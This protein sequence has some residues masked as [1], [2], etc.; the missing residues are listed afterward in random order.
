MTSCVASLSVS[1]DYCPKR[2]TLIRSL[3]YKIR[4]NY[5]NKKNQ[6]ITF[7]PLIK[8]SLSEFSLPGTIIETALFT[9]FSD[10]GGALARRRRD[11]FSFSRLLYNSQRVFL[12]LVLLLPWNSSFPT[13]CSHKA[14]LHDETIKSLPVNLLYL[15]WNFFWPAFSMK[16]DCLLSTCSLTVISENSLSKIYRSKDLKTFVVLVASYLY[17][18][19]LK[20][21]MS[22]PLDWSSVLTPEPVMILTTE[23]LS[24]TLPSSRPTAPC[25]YSRSGT[26][27]TSPTKATLGFHLLGFSLCCGPLP[28][29]QAIAKNPSPPAIHYRARFDYFI[30]SPSPSISL[31]CFHGLINRRLCSCPEATNNTRCCEH[32]FQ[33]LLLNCPL[34]KVYETLSGESIDEHSFLKALSLTH[35]VPLSEIQRNDIV[36]SNSTS[37]V[38]IISA[39]SSRGFLGSSILCSSEWSEIYPCQIQSFSSFW[40]PLL[41]NSNLKPDPTSCVNLKRTT[42]VPNCHLSPK[43]RKLGSATINQGQIG[44]K[45]C[46]K[47]LNLHGHE[48]HVREDSPALLRFDTQLF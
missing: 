19:P 37:L 38:P 11:I 17:W 9:M 24:L 13:P 35:L 44:C 10:A 40:V 28:L 12:L 25:P 3:N 23:G 5:A 42:M 36:I 33:N 22:S 26:L 45:F 14:P 27:S 21:N 34:I 15:V 6:K 39:W 31:F 7:Q 4:Q 29:S 16:E 20:S 43:D 8:S 2:G 32:S 1:D 48:L 46:V 30:S 41:L 47:L 18:I